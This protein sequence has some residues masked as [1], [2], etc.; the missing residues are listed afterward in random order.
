MSKGIDQPFKPPKAA[1]KGDKGYFVLPKKN[2]VVDHLVDFP[3]STDDNESQD[4]TD[5]FWKIKKG[6]DI[7]ESPTNLGETNKFSQYSRL[8]QLNCNSE[9]NDF[10]NFD[11]ELSNRSESKVK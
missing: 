3:T 11:V 8:L 1:K 5:Q 4:S 7:P 6:I 9:T 10:K 2:K